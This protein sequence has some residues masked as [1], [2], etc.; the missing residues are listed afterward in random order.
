MRSGEGV[1][2]GMASTGIDIGEELS[3]ARLC[4]LADNAERY[5]K[6]SRA[7]TPVIAGR[8]PGAVRSGTGGE[9]NR[10]ASDMPA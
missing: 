7:L 9:P 5:V 1:S 2:C 10:H 3:S 4:E 8:T 6:S